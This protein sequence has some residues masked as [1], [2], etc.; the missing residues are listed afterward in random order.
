M[1]V[2]AACGGPSRQRP[3]TSTTRS[4][5]TSTSTN[6]AVQVLLA[7]ARQLRAEGDLA[8]ARARLEAAHQQAP[9]A[10]DVRLELADVLVADGGEL[11]RAAIL[12]G[13]VRETGDGRTSLVRARLFE[14]RGD[15]AAAAAAY[16]TALATR[17]DPDVRLRRALVL[18]RAGRAGEAIG[19]L[20]RLRAD[21]P[22]D[23]FA[24]ARLAEAYEAAGRWGEAEAELRWAA[25]LQPDRP[26]GWD[27]LAQFYARAGRE[28]EAREAAARGQ[29]SAGSR[30]ERAL[31][32]LPPSRN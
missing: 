7:R 4:T 18:A 22:A 15:D 29:G 13:P 5:S 11:G 26:A 32:P 21:R 6:P 27:R 1:I 3:S 28:R 19:E 14:A 8:G 23:A 24:R 16:F 9:G 20:E 2:V 31:R 17:D 25:E 12:L 30:P 10:E